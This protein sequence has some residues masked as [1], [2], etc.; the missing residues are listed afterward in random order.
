MKKPLVG[1]V[2][3]ITDAGRGTGARLHGGSAAY[4]DGGLGVI[5]ANAEAA[6]DALN[7]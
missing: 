1:K 5:R 4:A 3:L 6:P 2:P 7:G